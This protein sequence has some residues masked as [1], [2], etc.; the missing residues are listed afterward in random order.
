MVVVVVIGGSAFYYPYR[1][2]L[3]QYKYP[4]LENNSR[5]RYNACHRR[6]WTSRTLIGVDENSDKPERVARNGR[7][8]VSSVLGY[9]IGPS[10]HPEIRFVFTVLLA[11]LAV[12][13]HAKIDGP[14]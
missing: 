3:K 1:A 10:V 7:V 4:S 11:T 13:I 2:R 14:F 9:R 5:T 8:T 12:V 6:K